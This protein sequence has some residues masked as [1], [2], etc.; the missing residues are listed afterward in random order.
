MCNIKLFIFTLFFCCTFFVHAQTGEVFNHPLNAENIKEYNIICDELSGHFYVKGVFEQTKTTLSPN[1]SLVSTGEFLIAADMGIVFI[2]KSPASSITTMGRD[3]M[4]QSIPGRKKNV[5]DAKGNAA[6]IGMADT[7]KSLFTGNSQML[8]E[9][10][11]NFF[12]QQPAL[13]GKNWIIG[14]I[15]KDKITGEIAQWII[16]EGTNDEKGTVIKW[17]VFYEKNGGSTA[18]TFSRHSFPAALDTNEKTYFSFD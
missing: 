5:I 13:S 10:F 8:K 4:I 15:P 1:R 18:Y 2:T 12:W 14:L 16:L 7:M 17:M 6:Y 11:E 9:N 3:F